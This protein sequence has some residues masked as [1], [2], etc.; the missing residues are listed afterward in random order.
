M[1]VQAP[2]CVE[3]EVMHRAMTSGRNK[4]VLLGCR[5]GDGT[6][7]DCVLK[8]ADCLNGMAPIPYLVEW[9]A[10]A[11]GKLLGINVA[12]PLEVLITS[13]FARG[14]PSPWREHAVKSLGSAFGSLFCPGL[15]QWTP[16]ALIPLDLRSAALDLLAFDV[17]IHN[18]DRRLTNPNV[19]VSRQF[20]VAFDNEEAFSFLLPILGRREEPATE[21][22]H[23]I[24]QNHV[25]ARG[26]GV[27]V[28]PNAYYA[29]G[30]SARS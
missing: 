6:V 8:F 18:P 19:L 7:M 15:T 1:I 26:L 23:D 17:F 11:L 21:Q 10:A 20:L 14:L 22:L 30:R 13:D 2:V 9:F 28:H 27:T 25:F 12:E 5:A 4:A 24:L 3:A 29:A 16:N